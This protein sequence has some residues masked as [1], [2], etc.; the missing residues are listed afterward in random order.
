MTA[1]GSR[2]KLAVVL[3]VAGRIDGETA[4]DLDKVCRQW[5]SSVDRNMILDLSGVQYISSA[6]LSTILSAGKELDRNGGR[7]LIA[8]LT[9]RL[10]QIFVFSGF[11][12]L[13]PIF[14]TQE[15]AMADCQ[16]KSA[17]QGS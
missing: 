5:I 16:E 13:F 12:S 11:D 14:D 15:T 1:E 2:T 3:Q 7:L 17:A 4:P 8:G 6:G 10:R 9:E